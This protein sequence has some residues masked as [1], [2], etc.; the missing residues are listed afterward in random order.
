MHPF[1]SFL[2]AVD[3]D[4]GQ[5]SRSADGRPSAWARS[6]APPMP[7]AVPAPSPRRRLTLAIRRGLAR[8]SGA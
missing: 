5:R 1:A 2:V 3:V 4:R 7:H 8:P 6:D